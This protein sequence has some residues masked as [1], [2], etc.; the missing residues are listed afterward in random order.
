MKT[1]AVL[2]EYDPDTKTYGATSP[3]LPD[4]YAISD[5]REDVLSRFVRAANL[6]VEELREMGK[7]PAFQRHHEI[8]TVTIDAA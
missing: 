6:H 2:L 1:L 8:V 4:V 5:T 7:E 3:D